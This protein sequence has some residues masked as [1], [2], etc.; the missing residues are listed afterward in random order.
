MK[1]TQ[2]IY[3]GNGI[4]HTY[5]DGTVKWYQNGMLHKEDG[6]AIIFFFG[7]QEWW[8]N[9]KKHRDGLPAVIKP[10]GSQYWY[11]NGKK[12]REDGP[13]VIYPHGRGIWFIDGIELSEQDF[14]IVIMKKELNRDL[15]INEIKSKKLKV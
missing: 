3:H 9:G 14:K 5:Q 4:S 7:Q 10:D 6:P 8:I 15:S 13:A 1:E 11:K 12:H 2:I